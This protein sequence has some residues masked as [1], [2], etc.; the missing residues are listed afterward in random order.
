MWRVVFGQPQMG[1]ESNL[2]G[3]EG[4]V[5]VTLLC[6]NKINPGP[7]DLLNKFKAV[8]HG[9]YVVITLQSKLFLLSCTYYM[10]TVQKSVDLLP[11][12]I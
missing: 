3:I 4:P 10:L 9:L 8:P 5:I 11:Y 7:G 6:W 2:S 1:W 12:D